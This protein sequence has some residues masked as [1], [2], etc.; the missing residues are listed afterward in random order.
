MTI[1]LISFWIHVNNV[2][3]GIW[4]NIAIKIL[5][6]PVYLY[7]MDTFRYDIFKKGSNVQG[8]VLLELT[9]ISKSPLYSTIDS[10]QYLKGLLPACK[11][12]S[13]PLCTVLTFIDF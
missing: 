6:D 9:E 1:V 8:N 13:S 7:F 5:I 12:Y 2:K 4:L 11:E 3:N 10:F